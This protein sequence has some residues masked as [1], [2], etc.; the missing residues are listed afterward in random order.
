MT[1]LILAGGISKRMWPVKGD[2][3][4]LNF[5]GQP[6]FYHVL[7]NIIQANISD[8]YIITSNSNN[9]H[10]LEQIAKEMGIKAEMVIQKEPKGMGDAILSAR[11]LIKDEVMIIN[12]DDLLDSKVYKIV[13][14]KAQTKAEI[15][16]SVFETEKYFPGGYIRV[17]GDPTSPRLRGT[18][19]VTGIVEKPGEGNEPSNLVR[20]AV[21]YFKDG[22][23]LVEYL[24]NVQSGK[25]DLYEKVLDQMIKDGLKVELVKYA[26]SWQYLKYPWHVLEVMEALLKTIKEPKI[27][28]S[29]RIAKGAVIEGPVIIEKGVKIFEGAVVKGPVYIGKNCIIGG[30]SLVRESMLGAGSVTGF[31]SDITRSYIGPNCWFHASYVGDCVLE[32]DF[33]AGSGAVLANLRLDNQTIKCGKERVETHREKL[34]LI[35]GHGVRIG[36]QACT[37][38]GVMAGSNSL[39]GPGVVLGKDVEEGKKIL[40]KQEYSIEENNEQSTSYDQFRQK[41]LLL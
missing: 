15:V 28:P 8:N 27:D 21:D 4:T 11:T 14:E 6:F 26:G 39:I 19:R 31:N 36:V 40:L 38:P 1:I 13:A 7:K 18:S 32:G 41:L 25:D 5:L 23:K 24:E 10:Q 33:G 9:R 3:L 34:G 16:L 22:K 29:A 2:K 12:G 17:E 35:A 20:L 30:N 37:M